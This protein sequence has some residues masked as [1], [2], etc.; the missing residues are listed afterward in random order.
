MKKLLT[1]SLAALTIF[2]FSSVAFAGTAV[3]EMALAKGGQAVAE[4]A[5]M[6]NTGI[7]E[8]AKMLTCNH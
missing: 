7:A 8:C 6:M 3:S 1:F 4:C 2:A 5:K